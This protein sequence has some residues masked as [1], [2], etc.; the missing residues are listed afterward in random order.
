MGACWVFPLRGRQK[1]DSP[2][3]R[4]ERE[5]R[6]T[7]LL[8]RPVENILYS[9]LGDRMSFDKRSLSSVLGRVRELVH[10][11]GGRHFML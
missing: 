1:A 3:D 7:Y 9:V 4:Q 11:E 6:S 2:L 5:E 8:Y 10:V